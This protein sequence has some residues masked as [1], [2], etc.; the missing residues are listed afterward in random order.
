MCAKGI[1]HDFSFFHRK[2]NISLIEKS[3]VNPYAVEGKHPMYLHFQ[4][5]STPKY[6]P[7][8][9][10][11]KDGLIAIAEWHYNSSVVLQVN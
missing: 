6:S 9:L 2:A 7:N 10:L 11:A 3:N 5:T 8:S 4:F 1:A